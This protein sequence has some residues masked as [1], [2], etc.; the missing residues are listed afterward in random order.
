MEIA[1]QSASPC[2]VK[3]FLIRE[4][5]LGIGFS[6]KQ[7]LQWDLGDGY[8]FDQVSAGLKLKLGI[9]ILAGTVASSTTS[10][11]LADHPYRPCS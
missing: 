9:T 4:I 5:N 3:P 6:F 7:K 8:G 11:C 10:I 2:H 1:V